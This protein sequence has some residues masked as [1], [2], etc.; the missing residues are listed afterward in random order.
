MA[1]SLLLSL[2]QQWQQWQPFLLALVV[3]AVSLLLWTRRKGKGRLKLPPGPAKLPVVGNLH[4]LGSL[5]HRALRDLARLHGPV[6]QL[7]LGTA[8]TVVLSSAEAAWE[9]LKVHD[10]DCCC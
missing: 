5:P 4:Q 10:L 7:Q 8:P 2:P 1:T 3:S 9:A 6:M